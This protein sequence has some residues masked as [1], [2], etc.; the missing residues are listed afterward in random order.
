[1]GFRA[2]LMHALLPR[3][4]E[5]R[6]AL[7]ALVRGLVQGTCSARPGLRSRRSQ[8]SLIKALNYVFGFYGRSDAMT[9]N[10]ELCLIVVPVCTALG[11]SGVKTRPFSPTLPVMDNLA[12]FL[13]ASEKVSWVHG[14]ETER[15]WTVTMFLF[16]PQKATQQTPRYQ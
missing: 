12:L 10:P 7:P 11:Q 5:H 13:M 15:A 16:L 3:N 8:H 1:M 14:K 2:E 4:R 9:A 6:D